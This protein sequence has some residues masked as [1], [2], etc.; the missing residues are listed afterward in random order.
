MVDKEKW[1]LGVDQH[2]EDGLLDG[3]TYQDVIDALRQ[4]KVINEAAVNKVVTEILDIRIQD[5]WHLIANN[6]D[7]IMAEARKGRADYAD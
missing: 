2:P 7:I 6:L 1:R 3:F 5:M 4:R